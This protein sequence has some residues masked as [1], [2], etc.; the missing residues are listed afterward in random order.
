M[1]EFEAGNDRKEYKLE[2]ILNSAVYINILAI[3]HLLGLYYVIS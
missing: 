2:E 3:S 1:T